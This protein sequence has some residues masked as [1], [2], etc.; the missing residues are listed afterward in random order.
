MAHV[1]R[2]PSV[3]VAPPAYGE[4]QQWLR[5]NSVMLIA[6]ILI[7]A[8]LWWKAVFLGHFYF[9]QDD[10][11]WMDQA[12]SAKFGWSYLMKVDNGYLMP[13]GFALTWLMA[14][15]SVYDWT[16]AS[17]IMLVLLAAA[18]LALLRLLRTLFGARPWILIPLVVYLFTP[19]TFPGLSLWDATVQW[20][21]VQLTLFMATEAHVRHVRT[22]K[23]GPAIAAAAWVVAGMAFCDQ[24]FLIPFLLFALT[25]AFLMPGSWPRA[26]LA[27]L[28]R[29]FRTWLL[30]AVLVGGYV[31]LFLIQLAGGNQQPVKPGATVGI[32][33]FVSTALRVSFIPAA[34]G[35]PWHWF[36]NGEYGYAS[37]TPV[38]TELSWVVAAVI[39][40]VSLWYRR[41]ALR[42]WVILAC[43]LAVADILPVVIA[44]V[45]ISNASF[46]ALNLHYFADSAAV[47][48]ICIGLAFWPVVG[49]P[50]AY[51]AARPPVPV[52]AGA[53]VLL[54][55]CFLAGSIWSGRTYIADTSTAAESSYIATATQAVKQAPAGTVIVS[56]PAP[57]TLIDP[58]LFGRASNTQEVVGPLAPASSRL[59]WTTSPSGLIPN[60]MIFDSLGRLWPAMVAGVAS[61]HA[62]AK[63]GCWPVTTTGAQIPVSG[64]LY[65]WFWTVHVWYS[66]PAATLQVQYGKGENAVTV[67][68][69]THDV[70]VPVTGSGSMVV[71][72]SSAGSTPVCVSRLTV[73]SMQPTPHTIPIPFYPVR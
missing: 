4:A 15:A 19:L 24:G 13:G 22:G 68:A 53:A 45:G 73:G 43:W 50:D 47:L 34:L 27:T 65:N 1:Q 51:R 38:L 41:H 36:S 59:R 14:R 67:P 6:V 21:P 52:L 72:S 25:S 69:G 31:V 10:F 17:V 9:R 49:E 39:I 63:R 28:R 56:A 64:N 37:E 70:Y 60:L 48:A 61:V 57:A 2:A 16:L 20:L 62:P 66:G 32:L 11:Q 26:A 58:G 35:G 30:Y 54:V 29:Y 44:R 46:L 7:A 18:S 8:E 12:L 5:S 3:E 55:A 71:I 33:D 23:P 42:A 40:I